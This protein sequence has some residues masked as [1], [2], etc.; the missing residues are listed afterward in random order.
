MT[1]VGVCSSLAHVSYVQVPRVQYGT[2]G[3]QQQPRGLLLESFLRH[4]D[5]A[6]FTDNRFPK[7][8]CSQVAAGLLRV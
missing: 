4:A 6:I 1:F 7:V 3:Y 8:F 5:P 2:S